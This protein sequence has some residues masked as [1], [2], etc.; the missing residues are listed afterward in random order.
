M[1]RIALNW[2]GWRQCE[3]GSWMRGHIR[4]L[5]DTGEKNTLF[6]LREI[7]AG[8]IDPSIVRTRMIDEENESH[9]DFQEGMRRLA[10]EEM[11]KRMGRGGH[12]R[13]PLRR[14][15]G[16]TKQTTRTRQ[17]VTPR[18]RILY[19]RGNPMQSPMMRCL[20]RKR[21]KIIGR[22]EVEGLRV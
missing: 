11:K 6:A 1:W 15:P 21:I 9:P 4:K 17:S 20:N 16:A 19:R 5:E 12:Q 7:A 3:P 8:K 14:V 22:T 13:G 18:K 10:E 2:Y